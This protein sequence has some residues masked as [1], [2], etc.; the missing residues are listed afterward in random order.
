MAEDPERAGSSTSEPG[1]LHRHAGLVA[2]EPNGRPKVHQNVILWVGG[3]GDSMLTIDYPISL[4]HNLPDNWTL[5]EIGLSSSGLGWGTGSLQRDAQEIAK[6]VSHARYSIAMGQKIVLMGHSTGCQDAMEYVTGKGHEQRPPIDGVILQAPVSDREA[7]MMEDGIERNSIIAMAR[8]YIKEG[9]GDDVLPRK[10]G[11]AV[12]GM[13]P[14]SAYR[15][16]S[17]LSPD[18]DGDDD[19]FSSDLPVSKLRTTF[20]AFPK[21]TPLQILCSGIDEYVPASV[22]IQSLISFWTRI[23]KEGGGIVDEQNSGIIPKASHNLQGDDAKVLMEL[24]TLVS[25]FV[26]NIENGLGRT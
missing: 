1:I 19:Y 16:L 8:A 15:W 6:W 26:K 7:L 3:L 20:G 22:N 12:F 23:V 21:T 5:W 17:L 14:I 24:C 4:S 18:K 11:E 10:F 2:F 25:R 13:T 9:R